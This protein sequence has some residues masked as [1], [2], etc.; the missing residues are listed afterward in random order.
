[1]AGEVGTFLPPSPLSLS[2]LRPRTTA[3]PFLRTTTAIPHQFCP[4]L[5]AI[6]WLVGTALKLFH[7]HPLTY[8][9]FS[10]SLLISPGLSGSLVSPRSCRML[11][12]RSLLS[13]ACTCIGH[14]LSEDLYTHPINP[15]ARNLRRGYSVDS[16]YNNHVLPLRLNTRLPAQPSIYYDKCAFDY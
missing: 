4:A 11:L 12:N 9:H 8:S 3:P 1:M 2:L 15:T 14:I 6:G 16:P 13:L 7:T 10:L 5:L